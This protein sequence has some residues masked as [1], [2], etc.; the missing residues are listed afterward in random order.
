MSS[1]VPCLKIIIIDAYHISG[2]FSSAIKVPSRRSQLQRAVPLFS[3][4]RLVLYDDD[5]NTV[6]LNKQ[7]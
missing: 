2:S 7:L 5:R 4:S 1:A 3:T 6:E